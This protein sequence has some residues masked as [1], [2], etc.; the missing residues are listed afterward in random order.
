MTALIEGDMLASAVRGIV[1]CMTIIR[2][3]RVPEG[4]PCR[5]QTASISDHARWIIGSTE[6]YLGAMA[7]GEVVMVDTVVV[8][9]EFWPK[10]LSFVY[11]WKGDAGSKKLRYRTP[12]GL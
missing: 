1:R 11:G 5:P 10:G 8:V 6:A 2:G 7:G 4:A 9:S 12:R 3:H